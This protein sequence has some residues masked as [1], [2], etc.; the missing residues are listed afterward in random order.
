MNTA[1]T[2]K[3]TGDSNDIP[4]MYRVI[5]MSVGTDAAST[6]CVLQVVR[7]GWDTFANYNNWKSGRYYDED[8]EM[9]HATG[10]QVTGMQGTMGDLSVVALSAIEP[11]KRQTPSM[12]Q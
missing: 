9:T 4:V 10:R 8:T 3:L 5:E 11:Y 2:V 1:L 6:H 12:D 7:V